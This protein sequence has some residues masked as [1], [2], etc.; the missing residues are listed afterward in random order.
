MGALAFG[1]SS[2]ERLEGNMPELPVI[3]MYAED[4]PSE[5]T[6]IVLQS[7]PG[8]SDR[9]AD[10]GTG[11]VEALFQIDGVLNGA[12]FGISGGKLY[13]STTLV[14]TVSGTGPV[15]LAGYEDL[16]FANAGGSLYSWT[17]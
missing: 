8:L 10:M 17:A 4:T 9:S 6:G 14:G 16:I 12:L 3:N 1:L 5:E 7:R 11:P 15:S 13:S 2:Y